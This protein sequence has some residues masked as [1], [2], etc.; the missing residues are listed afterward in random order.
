MLETIPGTE[1]RAGNKMGSPS[2]GGKIG[3]QPG[4]L[5]W[6]HRMRVWWITE[7]NVESDSVGDWNRRGP[8]CQIGWTGRDHSEN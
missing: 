1:G 7:E 3:T 4:S 2:T 8:L 5:Q 6:A